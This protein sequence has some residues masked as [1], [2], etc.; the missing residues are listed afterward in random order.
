MTCDYQVFCFWPMDLAH[1][2][3]LWLRQPL[4]GLAI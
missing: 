4:L 3:R 2:Q 1:P